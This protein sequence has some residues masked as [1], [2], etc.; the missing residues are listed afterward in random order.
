[1]A[2]NGAA[3]IREDENY[4]AWLNARKQPSLYDRL[5]QKNKMINRIMT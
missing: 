1:M 2:G 3:V 5:F 4:G